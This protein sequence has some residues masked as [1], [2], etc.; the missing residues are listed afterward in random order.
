[1]GKLL[2]AAEKRNTGITLS[3]KIRL[4]VMVFVLMVLMAHFYKQFGRRNPNSNREP[5]YLGHARE[6]LGD[7]KPITLEQKLKEQAELKQPPRNI[8]PIIIDPQKHPVSWTREDLLKEV[9][10]NVKYFEDKVWIW[11]LHKIATMTQ[12]EISAAVEAQNKEEKIIYKHIYKVPEKLPG[13]YVEFYGSIVR[14]RRKEIS[15]ENELGLK[16]IWEGQLYDKEYRIISFQILDPAVDLYLWD[17][18]SI[19]GIFYKNWAYEDTKGD[20]QSTPLI[21]GRTLVPLKIPKNT[22]PMWIYY[23]LGVL[24]LLGT[25]MLVIGIRVEAK[26]SEKFRLEIQQKRKE[27]AQKQSAKIITATTSTAENSKDVS[28]NASVV[29]DPPPPTLPDSTLPL[30]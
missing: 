24:L 18:V 6:E 25:I 28:Q 9:V 27:N 21:I 2:E 7:L 19:Q 3:N 5:W 8:S 22:S 1:M 23:S 13:L 30:S 4:L 16:V 11:L 14:I 26:R 17:A 15:V 10:Q 29:S 20:M 12:N